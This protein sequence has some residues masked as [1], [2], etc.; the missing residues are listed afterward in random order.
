MTE[1]KISVTLI[2]PAKIEGKNEPPGKTVTVSH[3]LALQLAASRAVDPVAIA[4]LSSSIAEPSTS[5]DFEDAVEERVEIAR[6][7]IG[8]QMEAD[9]SEK[10]AALTAALADARDERDKLEARLASIDPLYTEA[11][12]K[13]D[14]LAARLAEAEARASN[15]ETALA[16]LS[17][18][19]GD[20]GASDQPEGGETPPVDGAADN[21]KAGKKSASAKT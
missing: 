21:P 3:T 12:G 7:E 4:A 18:K 16:T 20:G 6:T 19:A 11:L 10:F 9:Y 1:A 15:A 13:I 8:A 2:G 5:S 17:A 14:D